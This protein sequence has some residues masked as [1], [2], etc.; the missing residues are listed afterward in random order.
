MEFCK[1][2]GKLTNNSHHIF[3]IM[4]KKVSVDYND[5]LLFFELLI[6]S[7]R[8]VQRGY[9]PPVRGNFLLMEI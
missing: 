5:E 7:F 2:F 9:I 3:N 8:G 4:E 1:R 6:I